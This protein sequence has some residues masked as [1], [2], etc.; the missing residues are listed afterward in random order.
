MYDDLS[1]LG[2]F[3]TSSALFE[4]D[5]HPCDRKGRSVDKI[6]TLLPSFIFL[7]VYMYRH[8]VSSKTLLSKN[9]SCAHGNNHRISLFEGH[10]FV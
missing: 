9:G 4:L 10:R 1:F 2:R 6:E 7:F 5:K 8:P 3:S